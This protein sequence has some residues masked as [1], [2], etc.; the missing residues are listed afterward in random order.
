MGRSDLGAN[1]K[2]YFGNSHPSSIITRSWSWA[3][4]VPE[5]VT[6]ITRFVFTMRGNLLIYLPSEVK[7]QMVEGCPVSISRQCLTSHRWAAWGF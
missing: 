2:T 3:V 5:P 1:P 7:V 6:F 4:G